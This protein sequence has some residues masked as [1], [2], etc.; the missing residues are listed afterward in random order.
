MDNK[1]SKI[2]NSLDL[3]MAL[4]LQEMILKI[5]CET[6]LIIMILKSFMLI[7]VVSWSIA[8]QRVVLIILLTVKRIA[9][10]KKKIIRLL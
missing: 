7:Y 8:I 2:V 4:I 6:I 9:T 3:F 1:I 5:L 10:Y